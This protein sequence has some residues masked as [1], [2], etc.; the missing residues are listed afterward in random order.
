MHRWLFHRF[1]SLPG[2][3]EIPEDLGR[4]LRVWD[5]IVKAIL[6]LDRCASMPRYIV[7]PNAGSSK[8]RWQAPPGPP[9]DQD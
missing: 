7:L 9:H 3:A 8:A 5:H 6:R 4:T 2:P 1:D